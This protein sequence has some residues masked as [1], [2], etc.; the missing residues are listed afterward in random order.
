MTLTE[1]FALPP[2]PLQDRLKLL[3]AVKA[4]IVWEPEVPL[5]P[6]QSPEALQLLALLLV[7]LK[8]V[9]PL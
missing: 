3:S 2:E 8:V 6:D 9:E 5:L 1:S 7:Q 4:L